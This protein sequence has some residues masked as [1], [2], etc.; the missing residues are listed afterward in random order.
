MGIAELIAK[1][2]KS[3]WEEGKAIAQELGDAIKDLDSVN[4]KKY[5]EIK[6]QVDTILAV[7]A[8]EGAD[9]TEKLTD[10]GKKIAKLDAKNQEL[11]ETISTRD[12]ELKEIKQ[13]ALYSKVGQVSGVKTNVLK[14]LISEEDNI[15]VN[16]DKVTVNGTELQEWAKTNQSDFYPALFP[17]THAEVDLP[18]GGS[19]GNLPE[20]G[21]QGDKKEE[22]SPVDILI[23]TD[24]RVPD[25][26]V[27]IGG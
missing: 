25:Y 13:D 14:T 2:Q 7:T 18:G 20:G 16:G 23:E 10:A 6:Q 8:A 15:E 22:K 4:Q 17:K 24:F 9:F 1:I 26:A 11:E 3:D 21:S 19:K 27:K 12:S 5:N